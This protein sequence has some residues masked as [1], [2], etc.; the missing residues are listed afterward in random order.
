MTPTTAF[1]ELG[2]RLIALGQALRDGK[3]TM[4]ELIDLAQACGTRL[5][6]RLV[7]EDPL[8]ASQEKPQTGQES[9]SRP[10]IA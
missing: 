1:D 2:Q 9:G 10:A 4:S 8:P 7:P 3:T 5:H 6:V